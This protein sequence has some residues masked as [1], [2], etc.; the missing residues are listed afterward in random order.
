MIMACI[1]WHKGLG[2]NRKRGSR[3]CLIFI[4]A[5]LIFT[6]CPTLSYSVDRE[7]VDRIVAIV[8]DELITYSQL[9]EAFKPF[10]KK[11]RERNYS[12]EQE[13]EIRYKVRSNL[14]Q[15]MIDQKITDQ[16]MKK[17][18]ISV[19]DEEVNEYIERIKQVN[20]FTDEDLRAKLKDE[21]V[22]YEQYRNEIKNLLLRNKLIQYQI[23]SRIVITAEEIKAFYNKHKDE[24][25]GKT[26]EEVT[27][28]IQDKLYQIQSDEKFAKWISDLR[29]EAQIKIIQ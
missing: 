18:Q 20:S 17:A 23:K 4:A 25:G 19:S 3:F 13:V 15:Q 9:S 5:F 2:R 22:S 24:F 11:I 8:N 26:L 12:L 10:E 7:V 21:D 6:A 27:P 29:E 1:E 28:L 14:I 16:E